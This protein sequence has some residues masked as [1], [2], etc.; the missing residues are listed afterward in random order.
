MLVL[1]RKLGE[2]IYI[3]EN[4]CITVVDIDRGKIRLGIEAPR[5]VP[6]YRQELLPL[7]AAQ[8]AEAQT[9]LPSAS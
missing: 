5:D 3:G 4:I 7:A 8:R 1:S 9:K 6:I 2:K